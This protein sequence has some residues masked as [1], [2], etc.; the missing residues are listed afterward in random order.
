MML[1]VD[2]ASAQ[3]PAPDR[4]AA[5]PITR[6]EAIA[7]AL[8]RSPLIGIAAADQSLAEANVGVARQWE[9]PLLGASISKSAPQQHYTLDLALDPWWQRSPRVA[10]AEAARDVARVRFLY[11]TRSIAFDV[12]TAYTRAQLSGAR[13]RLSARTARDADSLLVL[14]RVRRDAGDASE[15][16]VEL[17]AV[18]AGQA[19]N[20]ASSDSVGAR[21][22]LLT[23]QTLMG[24]A[25]D[26]AEISVVDS[27][28][29]ETSTGMSATSETPLLLDVAS[30]DVRAAELR[31]AAERGRRFGAPSLSLGIETVNPGGPGGALGLAGISL[32]IPVFNRNGGA[33]LAARADLARAQAQLSYTR[34]VT[35]AALVAARRDADA[36]RARAQRSAQLVASADRIATLSLLAY[37]EGASTLLVV[38]EAQRTARETLAQYFDDVAAARIATS[39]FRLL[40][41]SASETRP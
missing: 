9:N 6:S 36:A 2:T 23:V 4:L 10:A 32:P 11:A 37:R 35:G 27:L 18:F 31:V 1:A 7:G 5:T 33:I 21:Y 25:S 34:L 24:R 28:M 3:S 17:A 8:A 26:A 39:F 38:L 22:A 16:D 14:A 30:R 15:L 12:D 19:H 13:S 40:S 41:T 29:I 20:V